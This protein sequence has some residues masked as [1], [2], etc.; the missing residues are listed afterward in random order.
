MNTPDTLSLS[1]TA[2]YQWD[3]IP[4]PIEEHTPDP[5]VAADSCYSIYLVRGESTDTLARPSMFTG[6][7]LDQIHGDMT[8]RT[9]LG[10]ESWIFVLL[11][12]LTALL[13]LYYRQHKLRMTELLQSLF[14]SR[15]MD[16]ML[17]NTNL[18]RTIQLVPIG[19][20]VVAVVVLPVHLVAMSHTGA[21]GYLLLWAIVAG[22]YLLR[23]GVIRLLGAIFEDHTV[24]TYI[25]SNYI[26]HLALATLVLPLA[27]L[28]CYMPFGH[29]VIGY[30][31]L[32][33]VLLEF[34]LRLF[35]GMKLFLTQ[36][37][38][39]HFYL[40]YYLCIVELVPILV[41]IKWLIE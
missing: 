32:G 14:D 17:R 29:N 16:R 10:L 3:S 38:A 19:L 18:S 24:D 28:Y 7:G 40:F 8:I 2:F 26:Y 9:F 31:L 4:Y 30:G 33:L 21:M 27:F 11:V 1:Q 37:T 5:G 6:H 13:T 34:L 35:R 15:A 23:N 36:S 20:L 12:A 39:S 25:T 41:L 22:A